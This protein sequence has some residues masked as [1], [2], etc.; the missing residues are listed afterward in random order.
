M[1]ARLFERINVMI[2]GTPLGEQTEEDDREL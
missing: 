2:S 1:L